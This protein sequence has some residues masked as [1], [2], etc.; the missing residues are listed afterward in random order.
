M[1][2]SLIKSVIL[3]GLF[4]PALVA[5]A[6]HGRIMNPVTDVCWPCLF[7]LTLGSVTM[8]HSALPDTKN[9]SNPVCACVTGE[10][11]KVGLAVGFWEPVYLVDVTRQP[12]C[13]PTLGG[14]TLSVPLNLRHGGTLRDLAHRQSEYHVHLIKFPILSLLELLTD[15]MCGEA[16]DV[17]I[18]FPSELDPT[19]QNEA[20]ALYQH[21][22]AIAVANPV[23]IATCSLDCIKANTGLPLN[24]LFWCQG[25]QGGLYPFTGRVAAHVGGVQA[26]SLLVGRLLAKGHRDGLLW[27]TA[28]DQS[29]QLCAK[30]LS[31]FIPKDTYRLSMVYPKPVTHE[32]GC[33]PLGRSTTLW[34]AGHE[35]PA[36]GEDFGWLV[37]RKRNCC[38]F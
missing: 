29:T 2:V 22:E 23:M 27:R 28:S 15:G 9:P 14:F 17:D 3:I 6:C 19:W 7:P 36:D 11:P 8:A 26:S 13:F 12:F 10:M 31:P 35:Y 5:G 21:P 34:E 16:P 4:M 25:C 30:H 18:V 1:I 38:A 33:M 37:W 32:A 20:L 24:H